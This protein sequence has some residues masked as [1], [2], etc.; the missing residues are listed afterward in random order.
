MFTR[1]MSGYVWV[2]CER[3]GGGSAFEEHHLYNVTVTAHVSVVIFLF[4][5]VCDDRRI[6]ELVCAF[7]Y[8]CAFTNTI[9]IA[10]FWRSSTFRFFTN[11]G[12]LLLLKLISLIY[13]ASDLVKVVS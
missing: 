4:S 11:I 10:I 3:G 7:M 13:L 1:Y 6:W 2:W 12:K 8:I 5:D 9:I